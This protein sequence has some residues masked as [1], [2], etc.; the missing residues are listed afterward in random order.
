MGVAAARCRPGRPRSWTGRALSTSCCC[1]TGW[2]LAGRADVARSATV[3]LALVGDELIQFERAVRIGPAL[4]RLGGLL[5]GRRGT[6]WAMAGHMPGERFV[7]IEQTALVGWD[8]PS[9]AIGAAARIM[10]RGVGDTIACRGGGRRAGAGAGAAFARSGCAASGGRRRRLARPGRGR[11]RAGGWTP[12]GRRRRRN[13]A[14]R[15]GGALSAL[16]DGRGRRGTDL[17]SFPPTAGPNHGA[18][19]RRQPTAS[20]PAR[21]LSITVRQ[22]GAGSG[23]LGAGRHHRGMQG[24]EMSDVSARLRP[25]LGAAGAGAE[26]RCT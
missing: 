2:S 25:T 6:E 20:R 4:W 22:Q 24:S 18:E 12:A 11:S 8:L 17:R 9:S 15:G 16:R 7:L 13:R 5:R 10:A 1:M 23:V 14:R 26:G 3:N 19:I 21:T